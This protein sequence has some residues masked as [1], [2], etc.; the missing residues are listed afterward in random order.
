MTRRRSRVVRARRATHQA[1]VVLGH[2][3]AVQ[4]GRVPQRAVNYGLGRLIGRALR[5]VWR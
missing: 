1:G 4:T 2:I 5:R 3:R